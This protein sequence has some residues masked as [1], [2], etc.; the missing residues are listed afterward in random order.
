[1][2]NKTERD[3]K[4]DQTKGKIKQALG[5]LTSNADLKTK[6]EADESLGN[7]EVAIGKARRKAGE[8]VDGLVKAAKGKR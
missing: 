8:A 2:L 6:G 1:M 5:N 7:V 3:G 4:I